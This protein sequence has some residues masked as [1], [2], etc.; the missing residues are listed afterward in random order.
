MQLDAIDT[1]IIV[2][3]DKV[4][5]AHAIL[6]TEKFR[7][8]SRHPEMPPI[9]VQDGADDAGGPKD[10]FEEMKPGTKRGTKVALINVSR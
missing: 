7:Q 2:E 5:L 1:P 6:R 8:F 10:R 3:T 4:L 9:T